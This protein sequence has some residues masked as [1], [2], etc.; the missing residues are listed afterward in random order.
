MTEYFLVKDL[1]AT[2]YIAYEMLF[3]NNNKLPALISSELIFALLLIRIIEIAP[4]NPIATPIIL[5]FIIFSF[6]I[7]IEITKTIIGEIVDIIE[8]L[9]G[10]DNSKPLMAEIIFTDMPKTVQNKNF[11]QS[12]FSIFSCLL[13]IE[14]IQNRVQAPD[15]LANSKAEGVMKTGIKVFV[16]VWFNPK[17]DV[18]NNAAKIASSRLFT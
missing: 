15:T 6:I 4:I 17:I 9:I 2:K 13:N 8:L 7:T 16:T 1:T 3:S 11:D 10:L 18:A 14:I 12:F 5:V